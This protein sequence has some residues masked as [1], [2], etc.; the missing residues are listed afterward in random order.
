M[1]NTITILSKKVYANFSA[2]EWKI[3]KRS[4]F[5]CPAPIRQKFARLSLE[6]GLELLPQ[7]EALKAEMLETGESE[8]APG[9][10]ESQSAWQTIAIP[11]Y[12]RFQI[13][14][15]MEVQKGIIKELYDAVNIT[16][17]ECSSVLAHQKGLNNLDP[18]ALKR[19]ARII[20]NTIKG[21]PGDYIPLNEPPLNLTKAKMAEI[22]RLM[23]SQLKIRTRGTKLLSSQPVELVQINGVN[24]IKQI[25][26]RQLN[27][28]PPVAVTLYTIQNND[29]C[30]EVTIS[31]RPSEKALWESDLS[32]VIDTFRFIKR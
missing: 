31:Y 14:P 10:L 25:Y 19:Y 13:P 8:A 21:K 30:H 12:C 7:V 27:D 28:R 24:A 18:S 5:N 23:Q 17:M 22:D 26:T 15:T 32:E 3:F 9:Q 4:G 11:G 1:E 2:S 6:T 20:V 29:C 16:S